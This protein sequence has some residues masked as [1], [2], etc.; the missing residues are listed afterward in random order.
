MLYN[1]KVESEGKMNNIHRLIEEMNNI[2]SSDCFYA[3]FDDIIANI[4][5]ESIPREGFSL[6]FRFIE[7]NPDIDYGGPGSLVHFIEHYYCKDYEEALKDSILRSPT[8]Q[9]LLMLNR[10]INGLKERKR[11]AFVS[12]Y[13]RVL[14]MDVSHEV[15]ECA[16]SFLEYQKAKGEK[17]CF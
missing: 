7:D 4:E 3:D 11:E 15:K 8:Y 10:T 2:K 12:L 5:I 9:T 17:D 16:G 13:Q 1:F 14:E 6:I